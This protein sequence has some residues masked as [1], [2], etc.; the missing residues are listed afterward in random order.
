MTL[1]VVDGSFPRELLAKHN[2][3]FAE[4]R[5]PS[6][7]NRPE[8]YDAKLNKAAPKKEGI[9]KVGALKA[10]DD[11]MDIV[12]VSPS[13]SVSFSTGFLISILAAVICSAFVFR[14]RSG[15]QA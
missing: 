9:L 13:T 6:K 4:Y 1:T 10:L 3:T 5:M 11:D 14:I 15:R 12:E 2:L 8:S 7:R